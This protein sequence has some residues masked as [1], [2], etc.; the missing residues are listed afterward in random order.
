MKLKTCVTPH[1]R[2]LY[3]VHRPSFHIEN[4]REKDG[5][6]PL[7]MDSSGEPVMNHA[8]F[9]EKAVEEPQADII[10]EVP[11][12]FPF[13][14]STYIA[15]GWADAK[16][17]NPGSIRLTFEKPLSFSDSLRKSL[18][19]EVD[20]DSV[21]N[22]LPRQ[23]LLT[24]AAESCDTD[25]LVR[26]T[27]LCCDFHPDIQ[28]PEGL[29][30]QREMSGAARAVIRNHTLFET[31]VNNAHLPDK[32]KEAMVLRPGVQGGS[33][34]VG[35]YHR[36]DAHIYEYLRRN[37]Y[38]PWGHFAANMAEDAVRYD[39]A[40]LSFEDMK[41]LRHL[42]Y[43]R[44][45]SRV[46]DMLGIPGFTPRKTAEV[47]E[48][49]DLRR[50]IVK[51]LQAKEPSDL[52]FN[53]TLWGWNY[54]FNFTSGG[55]NLHGSHQQIHQQFALIPR[56]VQGAGGFDSPG[57]PMETYG[58][59]DQ[60]YAFIRTYRKEYGSHFFDDYIRAMENNRRMD[61]PDQD[62]SL[63]VY[64]DDHV[65]LFVPKA[66]T[67]QW[68]L[69]LMT[70]LPL[71][72]IL[73]TD[74]SVRQSLDLAMHRAMNALTALGAK[75]ISVIEFSGRFGVYDEKQHLLYSFLP[76]IPYSMGAFT[77]A[78]QRFINGHY[79]EDFALACRNV[80]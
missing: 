14:G 48:L 46:A 39:M 41:G 80:L 36:D 38:I 71:A 13:R 29:V 6:R 51:K 60:V 23:V 52:F 45:Y 7:G 76:K 66:Q 25:E 78:Q 3:G 70:R 54:G 5:L 8:N 24:I 32:L 63:V 28:N 47:D 61:K 19:P 17:A 30:F 75:M 50:S 11:N 27:S 21:F 9:P 33:E 16:S 4:F 59:G 15:S 79:P 73:E 67:S 42:Y 12:P 57:E 64:Q 72:N 77:E 43:Q 31:L 53:A 1:G 35:E 20:L 2:F 65:T 49:E 58:C 44:T 55:Y 18:G 26:L 37:S 74:T 40:S 62:A 10:Y 56:T 69:N 34:I 68:E 22:H